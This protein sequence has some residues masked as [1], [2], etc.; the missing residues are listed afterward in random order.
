MQYGIASRPIKIGQMSYGP[1][2]QEADKLLLLDKCWH[3]KI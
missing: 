2:R 3:D 1:L